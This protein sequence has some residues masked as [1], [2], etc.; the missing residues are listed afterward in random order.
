ML[1][2]W[3]LPQL[4]QDKPNVVFQHDGVPPHIHNEVM[5]FLKGSSL[6]NG[7]AKWGSTSWP[8]QSPDLTLLNFFLWGFMKD[9][10]YIPPMPITMN[11]LKD[12]IQTATANTDQPLLQN[13]WHEVNIIL[14]CAGQQLEHL[15][16]F[17]RE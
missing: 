2:L 9:E 6:S 5:T 17:H 7:S 14:M 1:K 10:V 16:N 11:N 12:Q 3:L 4:L 13:V 8:L 15:L